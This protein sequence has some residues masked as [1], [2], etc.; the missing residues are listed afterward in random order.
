MAALVAAVHTRQAAPDVAQ[1]ST[2]GAYGSRGRR[3]E[4]PEDDEVF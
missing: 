4:P 3:C 2:P 1:L